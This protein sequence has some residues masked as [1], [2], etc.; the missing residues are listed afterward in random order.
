MYPLLLCGQLQETDSLVN[1]VKSTC[2]VPEN[3]EDY[4]MHTLCVRH[5]SPH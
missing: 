5:L 3:T 4:A 2:A 1:G